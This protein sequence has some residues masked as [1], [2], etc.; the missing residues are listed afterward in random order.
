[1]K[2]QPG[3]GRPLLFLHIPKAAGTTLSAI[4]RNHYPGRAFDGGINVFQRLDVAGPRLEAAAACDQLQALAA[5]V[6]FG[7][8]ARFLPA[9]QYLTILRDPVERSL[10]QIWYLK[11]GNGAG[12][13]PPGTPLPA[14]DLTVEGAIA[15]G[16]VLDNLQTRMLCGIVSPFD[17]LPADALDQA[18]RALAER[19]AYV[20]TAERFDEFLALLNLELGWPTVPYQRKRVN[21][22][23]PGRAGLSA[24]ELRLLEEANVLDRELF[25]YAGGLLAH[26]LQTAGP[27]LEQ[28]L[29]VLHRALPLERLARKGKA[30]DAD[31]IRSLSVEARVAL[32]LKE[33]EV[34]QTRTMLRRKAKRIS[35]LSARL[36]EEGR[37]TA[38]RDADP[39]RR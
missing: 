12:Q 24:G 27:A 29:E 32:A 35:R 6:T 7:L 2:R 16:Y 11:A 1:M 9:A 22:L 4:L 21:P 20:G 23:S 17:A 30:L 19:F 31:A 26:T 25:D 10:S 37:P 34:G 5:E 38:E 13:V 8:A 3:G 14:R 39:A 18:K 15:D 33:A 36:A 28:E